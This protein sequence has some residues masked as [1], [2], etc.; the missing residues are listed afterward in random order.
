ML[1]EFV[2]GMIAGGVV[3]IALF[4][5]GLLWLFDDTLDQDEF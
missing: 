4:V 1:S 3:T 2:R 5:F